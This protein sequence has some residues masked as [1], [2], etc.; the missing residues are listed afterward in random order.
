MKILI[1]GGAGFLG[2]N[3]SRYFLLKGYEIRVFDAVR[4]L[5]EIKGI[6]YITGNFFEEGNIIPYLSDVDVVIHA[7]SSINPGNSNDLYMQ[8]YN[9]DFVYSVKLADYSIKYHFRLLFLS[10]GGTVYGK[11]EHMPIAEDATAV[12]INH[13]G[14]LKLCIENTYRTFNTQSKADIKIVRIANP[15]GPGQDYKKGVGLIDAV[16]KCA[17]QK[18]SVNIFG[19][20]SVIRDYIYVDDVC[21]MLEKV[22]LY[23]GAEAVFNIGTQTGTT[24][25][26]IINYVRQI[27]PD[28]SVTYL[29]ARPVDVPCIIL[30]NTKIM[31]LYGKKCI[32]IKDGILEYYKYIQSGEVDR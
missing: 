31:S 22:I 18:Q 16:L 9:N 32:D 15:Y 1:L 8:G 13:Y 29:P 10:S 12:P 27:I 5:Y 17:I 4:P 11:Q 25:L 30:N 21:A 24:Q 3:I 6:E 28:L 19:D 26:E 20:G 2:R 7:I 14:N 23:H